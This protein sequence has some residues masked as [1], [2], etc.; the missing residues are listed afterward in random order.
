MKTNTQIQDEVKKTLDELIKEG[1]LE[2]VGGK[3]RLTKKG[4]IYQNLR[5]N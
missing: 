5:V 4:M 2:E 3:Y 1:L